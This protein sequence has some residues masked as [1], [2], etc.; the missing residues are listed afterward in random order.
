MYWEVES[1]QVGGVVGDISQHLV[2]AAARIADNKGP[3]S[4][5]KGDTVDLGVTIT[6]P[7]TVGKMVEQCSTRKDEVRTVCRSGV[8]EP[9]GV[10]IPSWV[11]GVL[12]VLGLGRGM[13]STR[14]QER[15]YRRACEGGA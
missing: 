1:L 7:V 10:R 6:A 11:G 15:D 12:T 5:I 2:G 3:C 13:D 8:I 14:I 9:V 4:R